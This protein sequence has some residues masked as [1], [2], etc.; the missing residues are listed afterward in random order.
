MTHGGYRLSTAMDIDDPQQPMS[1]DPL[2][3]ATIAA[4]LFGSSDPPRVGRFSVLERIGSGGM[5]VVY[6]AYDPQ[7]QREVAV[8]LLGL[9]LSDEEDSQGHQRLVREAQAM[10]RI[11]DPHVLPVFE[12][13]EHEGRVFVAMELVSGGTLREWLEAERREWTSVLDLFLQAGRGLAAAHASGLVHRDFKPENVLVDGGDEPRARVMDF[14]LARTAEAPDSSAMTLAVDDVN[15]RLTQTGAVLGTP[16]YMSPEQFAGEA[17]D[18]RSDQFSF[19]VA[20]WEA[21]CGQRPFAGQTLRELAE[22]VAAG[23]L[24]HPRSRGDAPVA[25]LRSLERG[26]SPTPTQRHP[27]LAALLQELETH[28]EPGRSWGSVA[29]FGLVSLVAAGSV[30]A[31]VVSS[32]SPACVPASE[33]LSGVWDQATRTRLAAEYAEVAA[34][35][36]VPRSW[37]RVRD[38]TDQWVEDWQTQ[39]GRACEHEPGR[40]AAARLA[41]AQR[42]ACLDAALAELEMTVEVHHETDKAF[43]AASGYGMELPALEDCE[44]DAA[45]RRL[46]PLPSDAQVHAAVTDLRRELTRVRLSMTNPQHA[47]TQAQ[48]L[49]DEAETLGFRPVVVEAMAVDALAHSQIDREAGRVSVRAALRAAEVA[50]HEAVRFEMLSLLHSTMADDIGFSDIQIDET[51][52]VTAERKQ[53]LERLRIASQREGVTPKMR[54]RVATAEARS[55]V[56]EGRMVDAYKIYRAQLERAQADGDL[57]AQAVAWENIATSH[58]GRSSQQVIFDAT[59][60]AVELWDAHLGPEHPA[61]WRARNMQASNLLYRGELAAGVE[62][63]VQ[64]AR[65]LR[66]IHPQGH[67]R[68]SHMDCET[69]Q[70]KMMLGQPAEA[71]DL[72][73]RAERDLTRLLGANAS[74]T[75]QTATLQLSRLHLTR[76]E[77]GE[78]QPRLERLL[79]PTTHIET[80]VFA[81]G[82]AAEFAARKGE[83]AQMESLLGNFAAVVEASG[84]QPMMVCGLELSRAIDLHILGDREGSVA[85]AR[86]ATK[87]LKGS[88]RFDARY[89]F[90][91]QAQSMLAH[92]LVEQGEHAEALP[93]LELAL[94][95]A[96]GAASYQLIPFGAWLRADLARALWGTGGDRTRARQLAGEALRGYEVMDIPELDDEAAALRRWL[97]EHPA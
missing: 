82:I 73:K 83:R 53:L 25:L 2:E 35:R 88:P 75:L 29:A 16:A 85:A 44:D 38:R 59:Q 33:R 21:L 71:L 9:D 95:H 93:L 11:S 57:A 24:V 67:S 86:A 17:A 18:E 34:V 90:D 91:T 65:G 48:A 46:L 10:A 89:P 28:V 19:C 52:E 72:L 66:A 79:A 87:A 68:A 62:I 92:L 81:F 13:G 6:R 23:D 5:G 78:V 55:A 37:E 8:K 60:R 32:R 76:G 69:A 63:N 96:P 54:S 36:Y 51:P 4:K 49:I 40:D 74:Q 58:Y 27:D 77:Y 43:A 3:R 80:R 61:S 39:Y 14:G 70:G 94:L 42:M 64:A 47:R 30:T 1:S 50:E 31:L 15:V 26:L 7:L 97:D 22:N 84:S 41:H 20:L 56:R 12:S 45:L